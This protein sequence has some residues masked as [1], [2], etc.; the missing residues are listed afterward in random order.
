M[1]RLLSD[2]LSRDIF[3]PLGHRQ[4]FGWSVVARIWAL[5]I[6]GEE[7][8]MGSPLPMKPQQI[9]CCAQQQPLSFDLVES[10]DCP[11][12]ETKRFLTPSKQWF[13]N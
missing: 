9:H 13:D 5:T 2:V 1:D 12:P 7:E 10:P 11:A 8:F 3:I 4:A 6:S